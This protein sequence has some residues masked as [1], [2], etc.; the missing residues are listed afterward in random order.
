MSLQANEDAH[1]EGVLAKI[2]S[3]NAEGGLNVSVQHKNFERLRTILLRR[4]LRYNI[5]DRGS[6]YTFVYLD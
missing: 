5:V 4:Q 1:D 2:E 3:W 6:R